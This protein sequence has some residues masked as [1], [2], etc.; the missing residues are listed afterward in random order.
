M[1]IAQDVREYAAQRGI[2][3]QA[4]LANEF[5]HGIRSLADVDAGVA[6]FREG[7][8][9]HF[10]GALERAHDLYIRELV[11]TD[12]MLEGMAAFLEKRSPSWKNR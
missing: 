9:R 1:K 12:D 7:A 10:E 2:D 3:E 11:R 5:G 6:R 4:A 8:G